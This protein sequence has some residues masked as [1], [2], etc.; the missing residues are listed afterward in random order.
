MPWGGGEIVEEA[1]FEGE[2]SEPVFQLMRY[3]DGSETIRFCSYNHK[4][5]FQRSPLMLGT[6]DLKKMR[7]ALKKTPRLQKLLKQLVAD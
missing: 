6:G 5:G 4:G 1:S 2:W 7:A 3:E